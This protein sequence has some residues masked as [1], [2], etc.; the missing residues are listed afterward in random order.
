MPAGAH[1]REESGRR[2]LPGWTLAAARSSTA[3][4]VDAASGLA[5]DCVSPATDLSLHA[6]DKYTELKTTWI[7]F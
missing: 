6:L 7:K 1:S 5:F 3:S 4:W 2:S